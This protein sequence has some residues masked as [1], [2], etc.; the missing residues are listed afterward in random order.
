M[1]TLLTA[2]GAEC[3]ARVVKE[4]RISDEL[5]NEPI[6][7]GITVLARRILCLMCEIRVVINCVDA[8][9]TL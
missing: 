4:K 2:S 8:A 1:S 9:D 5:L 6:E 3:V 7:K